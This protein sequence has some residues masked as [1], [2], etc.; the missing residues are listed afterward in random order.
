MPKARIC[1]AA[2]GAMISA[3]L[4]G[5]SWIDPERGAW[6]NIR[7]G[8]PCKRAV[9]RRLAITTLARLALTPGVP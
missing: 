1:R 2:A 3:R 7:F 5:A 8:S 9:A 4:P 6:W